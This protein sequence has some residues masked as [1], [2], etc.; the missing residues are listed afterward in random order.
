VPH[1]LRL[2]QREWQAIVYGPAEILFAPDVAFGCLN[3]G[4]SEKKLDL[5]QLPTSGVAQPGARPPQVMRG[6]RLY[7]RPTRASFH[8]VP[9][10][11]LCDAV[12]PNHAVL[13]YRS[14][15]LAADDGYALCPS[16]NGGLDPSWNGNRSHAAA[17]AH[18]IHDCP[19]ILAP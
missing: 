15:E 14:E 8:Y 11:V 10:N 3:G 18:E 16:V 12:A 7:F 9:N 4:V 19:V 5:F 17:L 1:G 13:A 2:S 6:E